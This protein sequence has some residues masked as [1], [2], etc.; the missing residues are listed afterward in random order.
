MQWARDVDAGL[1]PVYGG[2]MSNLKQL[3][4]H[5]MHQAAGAKFAAFAGY[6]MPV[7]YTAGASAEH[8]HTW[9]KTGLFDVSHMGSI[10]QNTGG[11]IGYRASKSA[12]DSMNKSLSSEFSKEGFVF[13]V[14]HT[15]W[16]RTEMTNKRATYS[17]DESA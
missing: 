14:L 3:P 2:L 11:A 8:L 10:E 13:V 12:L 16:V 17:T 5:T 6:V 9:Q 4:L 15:G 1:T 7:Q